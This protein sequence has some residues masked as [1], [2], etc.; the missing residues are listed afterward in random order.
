MTIDFVFTNYGE[1]YP[2]MVV[3]ES[4][5]PEDTIVIQNSKAREYI[6][7]AQNKKDREVISRFGHIVPNRNVATIITVPSEEYQRYQQPQ[8]FTWEEGVYDRKTLFII[9][10]GASAF[11]Q[12]QLD[13]TTV[14]RLPLGNELFDTRYADLYGKYPGVG[15]SLHNLQGGGIKDIEAFFEEEWKEIFFGNKE[16][17]SRHINIQYYVQDLLQK[18]SIGIAMS[19][20]RNLYA[21]LID[22]LQKLHSRDTKRKFAFVSFNQ[23]TVLE[24]FL[25]R[26]SE[27]RT[28]K[29]NDYIRINEGA[30]SLFKPHGSWNWGWELPMLGEGRLSSSQWLFENKTSYYELYFK[31]L[32]DYRAMLDWNSFGP[33]AELNENRIG[34]FGVN[35]E[36]LKV[37]HEWNEN[38]YFPALLLPYKDKDEFTMPLGHV[39]NLENYLRYVETLV[40]IGWKGNERQ[41]NN[42]LKRQGEHIK[43]LIIAD[44][45]AEKVVDNLD[46]LRQ[47]GAAVEI[48]RGGFEDFIESGLNKEFSLL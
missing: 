7:L 22:R 1:V 2:G 44:P 25:K 14:D 32:G 47:A 43:K 46:F 39:N 19:N 31:K 36:N 12:Y 41:F 37:I 16:V 23:D 5:Y 11:C 34:K 20:Q 45:A 10:A 21:A 33:E 30:F 15:Y 48:Y 35:K 26:Y 4:Q 29:L 3:H 8:S 40:I 28:N 13:G 24:Y 9:G 17:M 42:L 18:K 27:F 38:M 6:A